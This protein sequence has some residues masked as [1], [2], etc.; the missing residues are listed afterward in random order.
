M[1]IK[2]KET[3]FGY[4]AD[5]KY[6]ALSEPGNSIETKEKEV[7]DYQKKITLSC[8]NG[9]TW[10]VEFDGLVTPRDIKRLRRVLIVGYAK[11]SRRRSTVRIMQR[12][13]LDRKELVDT[14]KNKKDNSDDSTTN[15]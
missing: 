7:K 14:P 3:A 10:E 2:Q 5:G 4:D 6:K 1:T 9:K 15:R 12:Q 11:I 8:L 13:A